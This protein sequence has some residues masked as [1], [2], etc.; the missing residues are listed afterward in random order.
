MPPRV[1]AVAEQVLL[2]GGDEGGS[3][4][5]RRGRLGW[6]QGSKGR[7]GGGQIEAVAERAKTGG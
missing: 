4:E 5:G 7:R 1:A 6:R 3:K 2:R